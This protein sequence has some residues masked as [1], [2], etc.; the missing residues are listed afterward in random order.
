[1]KPAESN[2]FEFFVDEI[3]EYEAE[4]KYKKAPDAVETRQCPSCANLQ[5][6]EEQNLYC[7][8][9]PQKAVEHGASITPDQ[10]LAQYNSRPPM[11]INRNTGRPVNA[12]PII[13]TNP[14]RPVYAA[15]IPINSNPGHLVYAAPRLCNC[16]KPG[17]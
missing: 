2:R 16:R 12:A 13:N 5:P 8:C 17:R 15:P 4:I 10:V 7:A 9:S 3:I 11:L 6:E 14:G 1:M